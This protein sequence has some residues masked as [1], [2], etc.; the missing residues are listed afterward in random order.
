MPRQIANAVYAILVGLVFWALPCPALSQTVPPVL[1]IMLVLDNSGSMQ[2]NDPQFLTREVVTGFIESFSDGNR[3][4]LVIFDQ[5]ARLASALAAA[6]GIKAR[7]EMVGALASVTYKGLFSDIPAAVERAMYELK[8]NARPEAA[9]VIVLLTDG[10]VDTGNKAIDLDKARWL[11]DELTLEAKQAAIRIFGIA[12]TEQAD[13]SLIQTLAIKTEGAYFRA[14][15]PEDIRPVFDRIRQILTPPPV[16]AEQ[17]QPEGAPPAPPIPATPPIPAAPPAAPPVAPSPSPLP[18]ATPAGSWIPWLIAAALAVAFA[19]G[20]AARRRR[21]KGLVPQTAVPDGLAPGQ[22]R[23]ELIDANAIT[24]TKVFAIERRICMIG[25]DRHND[26]A[27]DKD[28]VS[29]FHAAIEFRDGFYFIED[30]RSKNHTFLNGEC[31]IPNDPRKLKSGDEILINIFKFKFIIPEQIPTGETV[32]DFSGRAQTLINAQAA[33]IRPGAV[34]KAM[35]I[36]VKNISGQKALAVN[37]A[38]FRIGRGANNDLVIDKGS[39]SGAHATVEFKEGAF[40]LEDQR[41]TNKTFLNGRA[42]EPNEKVK[43]KSGDEIGF[44]VFKFIFMIE[45]QTPSGDTDESVLREQGRRR[46]DEG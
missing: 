19:A 3:I 21:N 4:G 24:G 35:L 28:T 15:R 36:D 45:H 44:D 9:K 10:M 20:W 1:D 46:T 16:A 22:P 12:F 34:P 43:L 13:F 7:A 18:A 31:L 29:S 37:K 33:G 39:I 5:Q 25:R 8:A 6:A 41:S 27:I 11:K 26:V 40:F 23:A 30:Q 38:V 17:P 2:K 14:L 42:L 32:M